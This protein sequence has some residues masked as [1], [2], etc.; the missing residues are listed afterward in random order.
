[1]PKKHSDGGGAGTKGGKRVQQA[2]ASGLFAGE[3]LRAVRGIPGG[4]NFG[5]RVRHAA[6]TLPAPQAKKLLRTAK[7]FR[8]SL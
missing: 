5:Q 2:R 1:M 6:S 4:G 7:Q 8:K 3:A